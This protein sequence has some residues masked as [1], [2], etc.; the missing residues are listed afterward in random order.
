MARV[1]LFWN[2]TVLTGQQM[3]DLDE[4]TTANPID[5]DGGG[6]HTLGNAVTIAGAGLILAGPMSMAG[7]S[8]LVSAGSASSKLTFDGALAS[9]LPIF[10]AGHAEASRAPVDHAFNWNSANSRAWQLR[11]TLVGPIGVQALVIGARF[12]CSLRV[13][14]GETLT[15]VTFWLASGAVRAGVP[16]YLPRFRLFRC[17]A[18][19][20][21]QPLR[22]VDTLT[23]GD[24]FLEYSP[25]PASAA[26]WFNGGNWKSFAYGCNQN[27]AIDLSRYRYFAE[28]QDER[29]TNAD[30]GTGVGNG[31]GGIDTTYSG[32]TRL[33]MRKNA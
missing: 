22:A 12:C 4:A 14:D 33:S 13:L 20:R 19:G 11:R 29:G 31:Y 16:Q 10:G 30:A 25:R 15:G 32:I 21:M 28:I 8:P 9:N 2:P 5:G 1:A 7:G 17:D 3:R 18:A 6:A 23:D 27:N 26:A 24:G